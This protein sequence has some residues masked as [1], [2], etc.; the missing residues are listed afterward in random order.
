MKLTR[1]NLFL[2]IEKS[3]VNARELHTDAKILME[4]NRFERSYT[5]FQFCIEE[6]GKASL[7]YQFLLDDD[8]SKSSRFLNDLRDH[9]TKTNTA[10]GIDML[11][12]KAIENPALKKNILLNSQIQSKN[13]KHLNDYK[14]YSLY[15]SFINGNP[16]MPSE[17]I[18]SKI[19]EEIEF[20]ATIR[21]EIATQFLK[22]GLQ[23]FDGVLE[24][25][26]SMDK[27]KV[28]KKMID[29]VEKILLT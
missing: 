17:I 8:W 15:V 19:L 5:C 20:Y 1:Q 21:L 23:E 4:N 26:K 2:T 14:N 12:L 10:I 16:Y 13:L 27:E 6:I 11:V 18:T 29:E 28:I 7:A 3:I 25:H 24:A 22:I 9:K